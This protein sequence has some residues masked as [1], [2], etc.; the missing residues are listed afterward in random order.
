MIVPGVIIDRDAF[1]AT[2]GSEPPRKS[3]HIDDPRIVTFTENCAA[4]V[5]LVTAHP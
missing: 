4:L 2:P 5:Y 3:H 1:L